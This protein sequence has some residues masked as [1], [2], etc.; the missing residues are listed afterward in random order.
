MNQIEQ[1]S[2]Q[3]IALQK[4]HRRLQRL[5]TSIGVCLTLLFLLGAVEATKII[6]DFSVSGLMKCARLD[7]EEKLSIGNELSIGKSLKVGKVDPI[8]EISSLK[9]LGDAHDKLLTTLQTIVNDQGKV[10]WQWRGGNPP[11]DAGDGKVIEFDFG[12]PVREATATVNHTNLK[13]PGS[14]DHNLH[15]IYVAA[16]IEKIEGSK[17]FVRYRANFHDNGGNHSSGGGIEIIVL[18]RL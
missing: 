15:R 11:T 13:F 14:D 3:F 10:A 16:N 2:D 17:V 12:K 5:T 8:V 6:G 4:S 1:L 9:T 7:V 18:A